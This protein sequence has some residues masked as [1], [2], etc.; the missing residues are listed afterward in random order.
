MAIII[1]DIK[2][3]I[4]ESTPP[5]QLPHDFD[6]WTTVTDAAQREGLPR[7]TADDCARYAFLIASCL[8][9]PNPIPI[10]L[11]TPAVVAASRPTLMFWLYN[12]RVPPISSYY[13]PSA[14]TARPA[15]PTAPPSP[16]TH[17][18]TD[19]QH[20]NPPRRRRRR[21]EVSPDRHAPTLPPRKRPTRGSYAED[22]DVSDPIPPS[23]TIKPAI[24]DPYLHKLYVG[25]SEDPPDAGWGLFASC[26][27]PDDS[28]ICEYKG[29]ID[30]PPQ[31]PP[32]SYVF[33]LKYKDGSIHTIDAY[34]P[35]LK[36][37][38]SLGGYFCNRQRNAFTH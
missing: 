13:S 30:A 36:R 8:A 24:N 21:T 3:F 15:P 5:D 9:S 35:V 6:A 12:G 25:K 23:E 20:P 19:H 26:S 22:S 27:I 7:Q 32:S 33:T 11:L 16:P 31:S 34:D 14:T 1:S 38:I 29:R 10:S 2:R 4:K 28:I 18:P 37:V 17:D